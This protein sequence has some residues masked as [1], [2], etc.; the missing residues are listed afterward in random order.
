MSKSGMESAPNAECADMADKCAATI[1]APEE[2][3]DE[4]AE[5]TRAARFKAL[6][7]GEFKA[8]YAEVVQGEVEKQL[9]GNRESEKRQKSVE[10]A[11][12]LLEKR[13]GTPSGDTDAL[14]QALKDDDPGARRE[15]GEAKRR[16]KASRL[17]RSWL[18]ESCDL[19]AA[20]PGFDLARELENAEFKELLRSGASVKA[21]YELANRA[22]LMRAAAEEMER[23]VTQR[24]L[25]GSDRPREGGLA[26]QS[27]AVVKTDVAAMSKSARQDIIR[28]VAGGERISF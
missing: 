6:I 26:S 11:V 27:A 10:K 25:S 3:P 22:E 4:T 7:E 9:A 23:K 8:E 28:R 5:E 15:A 1:A 12:K 24:I 16:E 20:Y 21:A 19:R 14:L 17:Y 2:K 13:Y 18:R